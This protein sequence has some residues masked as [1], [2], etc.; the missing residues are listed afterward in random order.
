[1]IASIILQIRLTYFYLAFSLH[2]NFLNSKICVFILKQSNRNKG[3]DTERSSFGWF[4]A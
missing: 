2:M 4:T 1:M 3:R